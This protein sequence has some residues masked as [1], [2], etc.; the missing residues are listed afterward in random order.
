M[1]REGLRELLFEVA[2]QLEN[3]PEFPLYDEE[4]LTQNRVMY[5]MENEEVPLTLH[6]IQTVYLCFQETALSGYSR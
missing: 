1:T 6:A 3:T 4:E 2:N 5:T